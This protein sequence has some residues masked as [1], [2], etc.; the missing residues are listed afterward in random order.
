MKSLP[1]F[2]LGMIALGFTATAAW[3]QTQAGVIKAAKVTGAVTIVAADGSQHAANEG[4]VL[5]ETDTVVTAAN[6]GLVLVFMN[7]SSVKLGANSRLLIEEFKMDPLASD[8]AVSGLKKEP[9]VSQTKLNLAYGDM[10]GDVKKLSK[11]SSYGIRTPV[12]AAGIRGTTFRIVFTPAANGQ[13]AAFTLSTAEGLVVFTGTTGAPVEVPNGSE[14]VVTAEVNTATGAVSSV[15]VSSQGIS[16][17]ASAA[18]QT[19]VTGA[20]QQAQQAAVFTPTEQ[21]TPSGGNTNA[22]KGEEAGSQ[23]PA[24]TQ[25]TVPAGALIQPVTPTVVSPSS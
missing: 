16:S 23:A 13:P 19:A 11:N 8:I 9:S 20:I 21:S 2:F 12:G 18:I 5:T 10:V 17:E 1:R 7:G 25:P 4:A 15:Q 6:S 22:P 24:P 3:A 14:V